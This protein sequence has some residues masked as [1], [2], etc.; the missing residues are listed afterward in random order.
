MVLCNIVHDGKLKA[1]D[2]EALQKYIDSPL[3]NVCSRHWTVEDGILTILYGK[4]LAED[5]GFKTNGMDP[6]VLTPQG[7]DANWLVRWTYAASELKEQMLLDDLIDNAIERHFYHHDNSIDVIF[8][9][10]DFD[11]WLKGLEPWPLVH[12]GKYELYVSEKTARGE[13][14]IHSF[15]YD[16]LE[17]AGQDPETEFYNIINGLKGRCVVFSTDELDLTKMTVM[18]VSFQDM[19]QAHDNSIPT[20]LSIIALWAPFRQLNKHDLLIH[21]LR[22][23]YYSKQKL[24][25]FI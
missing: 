25:H 4:R 24:D 7:Y 21:I 5:A 16:N 8:H 9:D 11:S 22:M 23:K 12:A 20:L 10:W 15:K 2:Q 14:L 13:I 6:R 19:A 3:F 17:Y 1:E 18:P